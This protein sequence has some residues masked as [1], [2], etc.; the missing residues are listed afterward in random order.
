MGMDKNRKVRENSD[1]T[2]ISLV[3]SCQQDIEFT[4]PAHQEDEN[5]QVLALHSACILMQVNKGGRKEDAGMY[6]MQASLRDNARHRGQKSVFPA[7][8]L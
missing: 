4:A 7:W 6:L 3:S 8:A 2:A 1:A 5:L